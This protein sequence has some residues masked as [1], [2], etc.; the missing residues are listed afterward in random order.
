MLPHVHRNQESPAGEGYYADTAAHAASRS[1]RSLQ[2]GAH[3]RALE[4]KA[5]IYAEAD[6]L[7]LWLAESLSEPRVERCQ[8]IE[9][10]ERLAEV[11]AHLKIYANYS[12]RL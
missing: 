1:E 2:P 10:I 4:A 3:P 5:A 7:F 8:F 11:L 9:R 12:P 6:Q